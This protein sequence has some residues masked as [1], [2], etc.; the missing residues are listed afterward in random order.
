MLP[1]RVI[2][3]TDPGVDDAIAILMA[4]ADPYV[5]IL[6]L[7]TVGGNVSLAWATRNALALLEYSG[8]SDIP[9]VKGAARPLRGKFAY[10]HYFHGDTG[11]TRRLPKPT[12]RPIKVGA[13]DF[14]S[15]QAEQFPG[16]VHLVA[17]GPLTNLAR[18]ERRFPG[19]LKGFASLTVMGGAVNCSGNVTAHAEFNFYSD[20]LAAQEVVSSGVPLTLVDLG[21]CRQVQVDR[22]LVEDLHCSNPLGTLVLELLRGWFEVDPQR[23]RFEFYD[24]LTWAAAM[25]P[26]ILTTRQVAMKVETAEVHRLGESLVLHDGGP[27]SV[28]ERV[29]SQRFFSVLNS[30]LGLSQ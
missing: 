13:V 1:R 16:Q 14:L 8:R 20:P 25:D 28:V 15:Q 26:E 9:V 29:D 21:A 11:L 22:R 19:T 18:L 17:L 23:E 10:A 6:G 5:E 7:T 27:V 3:D 24:P 12:T 2:I 30:L 4:L